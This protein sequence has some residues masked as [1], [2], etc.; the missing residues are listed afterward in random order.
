MQE[1]II[2]TIKVVLRPILKT[3]T[4]WKDVVALDTETY[5]VK[6]NM[7]IFF[8]FV[9][10]QCYQCFSNTNLLQYLFT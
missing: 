6:Q 10:V 5:I 8:Y 7:I 2:D 9:T 1:S 4:G 3:R